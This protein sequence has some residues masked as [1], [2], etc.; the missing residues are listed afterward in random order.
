MAGIY[1]LKLHRVIFPD[2]WDVDIHAMGQLM[3]IRLGLATMLRHRGNQGIEFGF[4]PTRAEVLVGLRWFGYLLPLLV[5]ASLLKFFPFRLADAWALKAVATFAGVY[6]V[7]AAAEEFFFR[8]VLQQ[9]VGIVVA[10]IIFGLVHM[11]FPGD[12]PNWKMVIAA[13][14]AGVFYGKAFQAGRGVRASMVTH[15]LTVAVWRTF[16]S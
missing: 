15:A 9:R 13:G 12:F 7:V 10:S 6:F 5:A 2:P 16:L 11:W 1:L 14:I 8:G 3:W 4:L